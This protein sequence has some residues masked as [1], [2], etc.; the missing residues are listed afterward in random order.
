MSID[1]KLSNFV[2]KDLITFGSKL[3]I[4]ENS[5]KEIVGQTIDVL[6]TFAK[7]SKEMEIREDLIRLVERG[8]RLN[9][10]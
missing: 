1:G 5:A 7:R 3:G 2:L 4:K 9:I 8:L 6:S 10:S